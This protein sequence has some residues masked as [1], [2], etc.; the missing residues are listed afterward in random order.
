MKIQRSGRRHRVLLTTPKGICEV[1]QLPTGPD[2]RACL[3]TRR[4]LHDGTWWAEDRSCLDARVER[5]PSG[6]SRRARARRRAVRRAWFLPQLAWRL[7][8]RV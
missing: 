5:R 3:P 6:G 4:E 8:T 1:A 7:E 2:V